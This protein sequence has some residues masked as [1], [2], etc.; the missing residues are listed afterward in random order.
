MEDKIIFEVDFNQA[1][2]KQKVADLEKTIIGLKSKQQE[3]NKS[4]KAGE[5]STDDYIQKNLE[6]KEKLKGVTSEQKSFQ[7]EIDLS[8]Q[9]IQ[10]NAGSYTQLTASLNLAQ[11]QLKDLGETLKVNEDGT[12]ELTDAY[13]QQAEKVR[14]LKDAQ[15]EFD[16]GIKDGRSNVGNYQAAIEDALGSFNLFGVSAENVKGLLAGGVKGALDLVTGALNTLG[17]FLLANPIFLLASV[18][19]GVVGAFLSTEKGANKLQQVFARFEPILNAVYSV[20]ALIGETIFS[21]IE[22]ISKA[23]TFISDNVFGTTLERGA[24]LTKQLQNIEKELIKINSQDKIARAEAERLKSIRDDESKSFKERIE[25]NNRLGKVEQDRVKRSLDAE[26]Q[27]LKILEEEFKRIPANLRTTE[28]LANVEEQRAKVAEISEDF[29][30]RITEQITNQVS[31]LREALTVQ[32][33]I[34]DALLEQDVLSGKIREGS[35]QELNAR[36]KGLQERLDIEL[37]QFDK[38]NKLEKLSREERLKTLSQTN[39]NAKLLIIQNQNEQLQLDKD[40]RQTQVDDYN[41]YLSKIKEGNEKKAE[42]EKEA[43]AKQLAEQSAY[44]QRLVLLE[45]E[46]TKEQLQARINSLIASATEEIKTS[47]LKGEQLKLRQQQLNDELLALQIKFNEDQKANDLQNA[48][49][50]IQLE[51]GLAEERLLELQNEY[52]QRQ[53]VLAQDEAFLDA[54]VENEFLRNQKKLENR[55]L[56]LEELRVK[57]LEQAQAQ[58]AFELEFTAQSDAQK[59]AARIDY[60][61]RVLDIDSKYANERKQIVKGLEKAETDSLAA[62]GDAFGQAAQLF[63]ENSVAY[64]LLATTQ[65]VISTFLAANKTLAEVPFPANIIAA[66][67]IVAQGL[68][69]VA[70]INSAERGGLFDI[71]K[72]AFGG[73]KQIGVFGGKPHSQGGTK[74]YFDDGTSIEVEKGELFAVVN[75]KNTAMI[76]GLNNL[77]TYGGNGKS[78]FGQTGMLLSSDINNLGKGILDN[79]S[80]NIRQL[81][82]LGSMRPIVEVSEIRRKIKDVETSEAFADS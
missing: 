50:G 63:E 43:R 55:Q 56:Y 44:F 67:A 72:M 1:A 12:I 23:F 11:K 5:I 29:Y 81:E 54:T 52:E 4:F 39:E 33:D 69:N 64:K 7:R 46:G 9:A 13:V 76:N 68:F 58:L 53:L 47:E 22:G 30:G 80:F 26:T 15:L 48:E 35:G 74:G 51:Q 17:K 19:V 14:K 16:K 60:Q 2:A 42:K 45:Q 6:L 21:V 32:A 66:T 49:R 57:E 18:L 3:L 59:E 28:Q 8:N 78:Y 65:A 20:L 40:F 79:S 27:K 77:N 71:E 75:K 10:A 61:Q 25:A 24:E 41:D 38:T 70:K 73:T 36:K 31:L 82:A 37:K 62:L 34:K